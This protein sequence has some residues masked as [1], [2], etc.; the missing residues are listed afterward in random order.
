MSTPS[1]SKFPTDAVR[2]VAARLGSV[3]VGALCPALGVIAG[4]VHNTASA[5]T[6]AATLAGRMRSI[7]RGAADLSH[8][9]RNQQ[10]RIP[11]LCRRHAQQSRESLQRRSAYEGGGAGVP[12]G[13]RHSPRAG[14]SQPQGLSALCCRHAQQSRDSLPR[15][16]ADGGGG[17]NTPG[18][19][20][21]SPQSG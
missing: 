15:R 8:S 11:A 7:P 18:S 2:L 10:G 20:N 14:R 4:G 21:D 16:R 9:R 12:G 19:A 13:A 1:F 3:A 6:P 5:C 17:A